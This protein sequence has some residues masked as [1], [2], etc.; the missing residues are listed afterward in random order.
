M[1]NVVHQAGE[2]H[3]QPVPV[4]YGFGDAARR[5]LLEV[6]DEKAGEVADSQAVL[7]AR[8]RGRGKDELLQRMAV[9]GRG[10]QGWAVVGR[11]G[12]VVTS[13]LSRL[14]PQLQT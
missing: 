6:I 9:V 14:Q 3:H 13:R 10:G 11:A 4:R 5:I 1:P 2:L 7:E 8:V 12:G